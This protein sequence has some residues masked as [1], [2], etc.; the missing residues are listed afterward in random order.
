M[1]GDGAEVWFEF[2][3]Y[4]ERSAN[5]SLT[6]MYN[7]C[8]VVSNRPPVENRRSP[9]YCTERRPSST[10]HGYRMRKSKSTRYPSSNKVKCAYCTLF[11]HSLHAPN[12]HTLTC[13]QAFML[14][15]ELATFVHMDS[16][17]IHTH[18]CTHL[19]H[20]HTVHIHTCSLLSLRRAAWPQGRWDRV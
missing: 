10:G 13:S 8:L 12:K 9:K 4:C 5:N 6:Y 2:L 11:L 17:L 18:T 7:G 3:L 1:E 14:S 19:Y 20:I 15:T 16:L